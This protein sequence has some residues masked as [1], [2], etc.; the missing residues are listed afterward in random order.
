M[1][2]CVTHNFISFMKILS[3]PYHFRVFNHGINNKYYLNIWKYKLMSEWI[4]K[5]RRFHPIWSIAGSWPCVEFYAVVDGIFLGKEGVACGRAR[6]PP[7]CSCSSVGMSI[8]DL[9]RPM[10]RRRTSQKTVYYLLCSRREHQ[11]DGQN[12]LDRSDVTF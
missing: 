11:M 4:N 2:M 7:L 9:S 6:G 5:K 8:S 1:L 3:K 10:G 12:C